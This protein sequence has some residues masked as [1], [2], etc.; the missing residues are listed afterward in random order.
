MS[1]CLKQFQDTLA[2]KK[3]SSRCERHTDGRPLQVNRGFTLI[4]LLVV[5]SIISLLIA[6]LMPALGKAREAAKNMACLN[7]LRQIGVGMH[8]YAADYKDYLP[9]KA[10]QLHWNKPYTL[11]EP[12]VM[13]GGYLPHNGLA[14]VIPRCSIVPAISTPMSTTTLQ[15][16]GT[17]RHITAMRTSHRTAWPCAWV[18]RTR[19]VWAWFVRSWLNTL[20]SPRAWSPPTPAALW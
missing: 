2:I 4:E 1:K 13:K 10:G 15:A 19:H 12:M 6:I 7:N 11:V 3:Q 9:V 16:T 5:I 18:T 20:L 8:A 14:G 17:A